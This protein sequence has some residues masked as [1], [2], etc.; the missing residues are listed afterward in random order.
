MATNSEDKISVDSGLV[1]KENQNNVKLKSENLSKH[2]K[3]GIINSFN[4]ISLNPKC[5]NRNYIN[6]SLELSNAVK[7][8]AE[9][10]DEYSGEGIENLDKNS[11]E[12]FAVKGGSNENSTTSNNSSDLKKTEN[13]TTND[14][15]S[16]VK[17]SENSTIGNN[18]YDV[19]KNENSTT[20]DNHSDVKKNENSATG[21]NG[22]DVKKSEN[23]TIGNNSSDVKKNENSTTDDNSSDVKKNENSTTDD[24]SFDENEK[25]SITGYSNENSTTVNNSSDEKEKVS[26]NDN[27]LQDS[28][29]MNSNDDSND[30]AAQYS[31]AIN[32]NYSILSLKNIS[33]FI[34]VAIAL[35]Y[36]NDWPIFRNLINTADLLSRQLTELNIP[37]SSVIIEYRIT[38]QYLADIISRNEPP[39]SNSD[40]VAQY[41]NQLGDKISNSGEAIEKIYPDGNNALME[42]GA[43]LKSIIDEIEPDQVLTKKNTNYF[44]ERCRKILSIVTNL[45]DKFQKIIN[46]LDDLYNGIHTHHQLSNGINDVEVFFEKIT[47]ELEERHDSERLKRDFNYLKQTMKKIPNIRYQISC[48]LS[49]FNN[50]RQMLIGGDENEVNLYS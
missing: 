9:N 8:K 44:A 38:S 22:S 37:E 26:I 20:D 15:S 1:L 23:S 4:V 25:V 3:D 30:K 49:E 33:V 50:H 27:A 17:K 5:N 48:L 14:N 41:L 45:R 28:D 46:E 10:P 21:N 29:S 43:E 32:I 39:S 11:G 18:S 36:P 12:E 16:D 34:I 35:C 42:L 2:T 31:G 7:L 19:K 13:S 6:S 47:P 40:V 24:N